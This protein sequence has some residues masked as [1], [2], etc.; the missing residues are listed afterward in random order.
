MREFFVFRYKKMRDFFTEV[1]HFSV[2]ADN[3]VR[4]R[5][6]SKLGNTY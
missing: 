5:C 3:M 4:N 1:A 6:S 2:F